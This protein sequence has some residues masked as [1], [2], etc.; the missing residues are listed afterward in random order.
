MVLTASARYMTGT[1]RKLPLAIF[2]LRNA[3]AKSYI[4]WNNIV[5]IL[6]KVVHVPLGISLS[7]FSSNNVVAAF[8]LIRSSSL[9]NVGESVIPNLLVI[10]M[11]DLL[12]I[13]FHYI[14]YTID[15]KIKDIITLNLANDK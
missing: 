4:S 3:P 13:Y 11:L 1:K 9:A 12:L 10:T 7:K 2:T 6:C 8:L 5:W 15:I 14:Y